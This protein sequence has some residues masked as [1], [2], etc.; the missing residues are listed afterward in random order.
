MT[1]RFGELGVLALAA[2]GWIVVAIVLLIV[3]VSPGAQAVFYTAG[4]VA[5]ASTA[6]LV[7]ELFQVR[8][9]LPTRPRAISLIG[10]GM[11]L[12]FAVEF[13]LWLQSLRVL[14]AGYLVL[15]VVGFVVLEFL[16]H[17]LA[18][19]RDARSI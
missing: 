17:Q 16:F 7:L 14:S 6:A 19:G 12:A 8:T 2:V 11:R 1:E 13:G 10:T 4:F 5:I 15:L 3:P 9:G 18:V